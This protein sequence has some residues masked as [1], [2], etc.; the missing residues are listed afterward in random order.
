M[1]VA[2]GVDSFL[3]DIDELLVIAFLLLQ[4]IT[5]RNSTNDRYHLGL[6]LRKGEFIDKM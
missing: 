3:S 5:N 2:I 4:E 1:F 6:N